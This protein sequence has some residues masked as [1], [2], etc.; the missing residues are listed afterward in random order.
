MSISER[1]GRWFYRFQVDHHRVQQT[2]GLAAT[3]RNLPQAQRMEM[4]HYQGILEGRLGL[5]KLEV[6][7]FSEAADEFL[8]HQAVL[9][10]GH[11]STVARIRTSL[12]SLRCWFGNKPLSLVTAGD[13]ER[14]MVWRLSGDTTGAGIAPVKP[15]TVRHDLDT[16]SLLCAWGVRMNYARFNPVAS[17]KRPSD[18][19]AIR[20]RVLTRDEER[21]YFAVARGA[22]HDLGRL[23]I[24]QGLRPGEA[25]AL[26]KEDIDLDRNYLLVRCGKTRAARRRLSLTPESAAILARRIAPALS[27]WVFPSPYDHARHI[28]KLNATH[29]RVLDR[30]NPCQQ[31][32]Q[33]ASTHSA[34]K[35]C[36]SYV[37]PR[38]PLLFVLYDLRHT[39][40]TRMIEAGVKISS[41]Q[42]IMG[43]T[44]IV[45]TQ[46]YVHL[47]QADQD[48]AMALYVHANEAADTSPRGKV[49]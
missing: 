37:T 24:L 30:L 34:A 3:A 48:E 20:M 25:I 47:S 14:F 15:I 4:A 19:D 7:G 45:V 17:V 9:R 11:E 5:R 32:G 8:N 40:A 49:Q 41:L 29:D 35:R 1:N 31:C 46:R 16:L 21:S 33:P 18:K 6:R 13:V 12:V 42:R 39:F 2:T 43:H 27:P 26:R 44:S 38:N 23:I 10:R 36:K 28:Q 22:L